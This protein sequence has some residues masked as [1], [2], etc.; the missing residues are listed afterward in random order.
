MSDVTPR[1][2]PVLHTM[3]LQALAP[4]PSES[5][6]DVTLGLGGHAV[7]FAEKIGE[8]GTLI[9]VDADGENLA[10][11]KERLKDWK[12]TLVL[13]HAN[14]GDIASLGIPPVDIILADLGLSS[15]HLDMP[16]RGF[17]FRFSAPLDMR[18]DRTRGQTA[19]DL[20]EH[21]DAQTL[22]DLFREYGELEHGAF[23]LATAVAGKRF[24]MTTDL[25][26]VVEE[27]YTWRAKGVLPQI[28]QA[29]RIAVNREMQALET[30]LAVGPS[31]L[32]D[33]GRMGVISYHSLEDR[34]TKHA[35]RTLTTSSKD[36]LTGKVSELAPFEAVTSKPIIP[37]ADE[38]ALNP[39]SR[40]AK[41]RV[42]R[43]HY[44]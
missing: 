19:A 7:S 28:F 18:F 20:I 14:F 29:L 44:S 32:K 35:F 37:S 40:S 24:E 42:I 36:P 16:E 25:K 8:R 43:R 34:M 1:H 11:A 39:R 31:L 9:G 22:A 6:L 21:S 23:K 10:L 17:S 15:P 3:V 38:I 5:A 26:A 30:L 2:L 12:G 33:G 41:F 13:H 4:L 27:L